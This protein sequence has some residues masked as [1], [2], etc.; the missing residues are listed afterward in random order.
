VQLQGT[1]T[2]RNKLAVKVK[3][4][5]KSL[6]LISA[7][8][9][10]PG[11]QWIIDQ[12][13]GRDLS[14]DLIVRWH[15]DDLISGASSLEV[16]NIV[17]RLGWNLYISPYLHAK[18]ILIDEKDLHLGSANLT[19]SGLGLVASCNS[20]LGVALDATIRDMAAIYAIRDESILVTDELYEAI[21]NHL[22]SI[23]NEKRKRTAW[24]EPIRDYF[25]K[26]PER[27]WVADLF[28]TRPLE[29]SFAFSEED[30]SNI[31][32]DSRMLGLDDDL[33][34][35]PS[36]DICKAVLTS[37]VWRWLLTQ[38]HASGKDGLFFGA[39]TSSLHNALLDDPTPY[40]KDV[41]GLV[42]NIYA[43]VKFLDM[44]NIV[45]DQPGRRSERIR[46]SNDLTGHCAN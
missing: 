37:R 30:T 39:V 15:P 8:V 17:K 6:V 32:H 34:S 45:I 12:L 44:Q 29:G 46:I 38:L 40:R 33:E 9:T 35:T 36:E 1:E 27:L 13:E 10:V 24:P 20:E 16:Y 26:P 18:A 43:W 5:R 42:Q 23:Q 19:G 2:Y 7:Y 21:K 25:N 11:I 4:A 31:E 28:W 41:K 14:G 3:G 22:G